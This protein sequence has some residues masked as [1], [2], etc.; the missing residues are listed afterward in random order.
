[1]DLISVGTNLLRNPQ[2]KMDFLCG[3]TA[4]NM[5]LYSTQMVSH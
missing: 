4:V 1:M 2:Y 3:R 5:F